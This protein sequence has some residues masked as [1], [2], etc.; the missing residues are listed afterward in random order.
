MH[1]KIKDIVNNLVA[2]HRK[3]YLISWGKL[4]VFEE[5]EKMDLTNEDEEEKKME[6]DSELEDVYF[7]G[8]LENVHSFKSVV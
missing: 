8:F 6:I 3:E 1:L 5:D 2:L 4:Q 7:D